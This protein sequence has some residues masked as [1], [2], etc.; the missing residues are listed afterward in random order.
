MRMFIRS[1]VL[2]SMVVLLIVACFGTPKVIFPQDKS[3]IERRVRLFGKGR[4]MMMN[5]LEVYFQS[6]AMTDSAFVFQP[7][8][9][10]ERK[11]VLPN[12]VIT[13]EV[14]T[15]PSIWEGALIGAAIGLLIIS[16]AQPEIEPDTPE[17]RVEA[18]IFTMTVFGLTG[19]SI[20]Q[21]I[22][23]YKTVYPIHR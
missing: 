19:G 5:R 17:A 20:A 6:I 18:T 14:Q 23:G 4:L 13:V 12:E 2:R 22:K 15:G 3:S 16:L 8:G 11:T 10:K 7:L 1:H 21:M 9:S